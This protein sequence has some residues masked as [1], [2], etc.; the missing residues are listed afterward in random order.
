MP[1]RPV[2]FHPFGLRLALRRRPFGT[3]PPPRDRRGRRDG[4]KG[5]L[6]RSAT[7]LCWPLKRFDGA[8]EFISFLN[9][10]CNDMIERHERN[11]NILQA[12]LPSVPGVT[13]ASRELRPDGQQPRLTGVLP[14]LT[15]GGELPIINCAHGYQYSGGCSDGVPG[16][17]RTYVPSRRACSA[18]SWRSR[19]VQEPPAPP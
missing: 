14:V 6:R 3:L 8:I 7:T 9:Q 11:R 4:G 2:R 5:I 17:L 16:E 1:L 19:H 15:C 10:K 18:E 12:C 13:G